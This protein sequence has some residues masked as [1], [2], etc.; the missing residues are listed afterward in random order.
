M[1]YFTY[2]LDCSIESQTI[3]LIKQKKNSLVLGSPPPIYISVDMQTYIYYLHTYKFTTTV[4]HNTR[5]D[6]TSSQQ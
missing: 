1:Y 4:V 5:L 3:K 6:D 2:S